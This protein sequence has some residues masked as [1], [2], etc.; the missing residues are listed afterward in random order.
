MAQLLQV[1]LITKN[2]RNSHV[3]REKRMHACG[4]LCLVTL[5]AREHGTSCSGAG[6]PTLK[7]GIIL[8]GSQRAA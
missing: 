6:L 1:R 4:Q 2:I 7:M 8:I 3:H 5:G